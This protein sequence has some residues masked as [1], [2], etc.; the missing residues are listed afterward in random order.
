MVEE[1]I[2]VAVVV[3][4][5][6]VM[7]SGK[8]VSASLVITAALVMIPVRM[9]EV[10]VVVDVVEVFVITSD[11][12]VSVSLVMAVGLVMI[13]V[14]MEEEVVEEEGI[15]SSKGKVVVVAMDAEE[16]VEAMVGI[17]ETLTDLS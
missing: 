10:A 15:G 6:F 9:E 3:V 1:V 7:S 17:E 13:P 2:E 5:V 4:E 12:V 8:V 14:T 16:E 11:K